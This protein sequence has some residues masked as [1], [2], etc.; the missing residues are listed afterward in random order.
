[1]KENVGLIDRWV[2]IVLG[3]IIAILG[4][5]FNSWWGLISI[6][7]IGTALFNFCPIWAIL[8]ISTVTKEEK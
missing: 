5:L 6:I 2:R 8:K 1:M 3:L 4:V 7:L